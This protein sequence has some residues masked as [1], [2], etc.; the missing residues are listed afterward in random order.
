MR[1]LFLRNLSAVRLGEAALDYPSRC[2]HL[3]LVAHHE[4][5]GLSLSIHMRIHRGLIGRMHTESARAS[6]D[7][8]HV[9]PSLLLQAM[10]KTLEQFMAG[11]YYTTNDDGLV[12]KCDIDAIS[13]LELVRDAR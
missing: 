2:T 7:I 6:Q 5:N 13:V 8:H 9:R 11:R 10:P 4:P 3:L 12:A 1:Q